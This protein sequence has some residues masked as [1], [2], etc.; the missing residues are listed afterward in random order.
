M[1]PSLAHRPLVITKGDSGPEGQ[2]SIKKVVVDL[3][4]ALIGFCVEGKLA[5]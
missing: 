1:V 5:Y 2:S 4:S 3:D